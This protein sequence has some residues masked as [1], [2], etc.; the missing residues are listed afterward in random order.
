MRSRSAVL[1]QLVLLVGAGLLPALGQPTAEEIEKISGAAPEKA[2]ARPLRPRKLLVFSRNEGFQHTSI[3][4][5]A[6]AIEILGQ[7]TSAFEVVQSEDLGLFTPE[8]LKEFDAVL[9]NN[10][11]GFKLGDTA[12]DALLDF[13]K[14]GKGLVGIHAASANFE[15]WPEGT[16][17]FGAKFKSHPWVAADEWAVRNDDPDHPLNAAFGGQGFRVKEEIYAFTDFYRERE[18]VLLSL[19]LSDP[20]TGAVP[21]TETFVPISWVHTIGD[22]RVFFCSLGHV[23]DLFWTPAVLQHYLDGI[24]FALGD[25]KAD[26][27]PSEADRNWAF[28]ALIADRSGA[29][30]PLLNAIAEQMR[31]AGQDA[32][33]LAELERQMLRV[34]RSEATPD[35]KRAICEPL[36]QIATGASVPVAAAL[37]SDPELSHMARAVLEGAG[38]PEAAAA[39]RSAL[40]ELSG[41]LKAGAITSLANLRD[42]EAAASLAALISDPD[43]AV[44]E[45]AIA[46]LGRIG[47]PEAAE[48]LRGARA[49][50]ELRSA[51]DD[52]RAVCADGLA[53]EGK[54]AE[55]QEIYLALA[56][57]SRPSR[58]RALGLRGLVAIGSPRALGLVLAWLRGT[59]TE[60]QRAA[61]RASASLQDET[62]TRELL[63]AYPEL[64]GDLQ[65]ALLDALS[66]RG[67]P[68]VMPVAVN[69][70]A[71][72][73]AKMRAVGLRAVGRLGGPG[74]VEPLAEVASRGDRAEKQAARQCLARLQGA[75]VDQT[76]LRLARE[77]TAEVRAVLMGTLADRRMRSATP[78]LLAAARGGDGNV[79]AEALKALGRLAGEGQIGELVGI[80]TAADSGGVRE[81]AQGAL[82]AVA[83]R[84]G[85]ADQTLQP[86]FAALPEASAGNRCVL[87]GVLGDVGGDRALAELTKAAESTEAD[88]KRAAVVALAERWEDTRPLATLLAVAKSDAGDALRVQALRGHLRL[89]GLDASSR[90]EDVVAKIAEAVAIARRP[91]EKKQALSLLRERR[92]VSAVELAARCLDDPALVAEAGDTVLHLVAPQIRGG[93]RQPAVKGPIA[94]AALEKVIEVAADDKLRE[95]AELR[96]SAI[97]PAPWEGLDVGAVTIPGIS[98]YSDGVYTFRAS[99][100]DI[101]GQADAFH[102][103]SQPL[104][105]DVSI[106]AHVVS[107]ENTHV[108]AKAGVMIRETLDAESVNVL[109]CVSPVGNVAFQWRKRPGAAAE[110]IGPGISAAPPYW[111]KLTRAGDLLTGYI[112][113]DGQEWQ[114]VGEQTVEMAA[115]V[116]VGPAVTSHNDAAATQAV[117]ES[118]E[119]MVN[120]E[121]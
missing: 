116:L 110:V 102:F 114:K 37:L 77:G 12:R 38:T 16:E 40:P 50:E 95:R 2:T 22:G 1:L 117:I 28:D 39:L 53:A 32:G 88:V 5:G 91:E 36:S 66:E 118:V 59:D 26:T 108:W 83:R 68:A 8:G 79:A 111:V 65:A 119:V 76:V 45:A 35:T 82:V 9:F 21:H 15:G 107:L 97:L 67:D 43:A 51:L 89:L 63:A 113:P 112:S 90:P 94:M 27:A 44:A 69:A 86:L 46:G 18:R 17:L 115:D 42:R 121:R 48:A 24:Q 13:V 71:S 80:L 73:D 87:L 99:G 93:V 3:P 25:L 4:Y 109:M 98:S 34:L 61:A 78:A 74:A 92:V 105:G 56:D 20:R 120:D 64:A 55:A 84:V 14:G 60:L 103:V 11:Y 104:S 10:G 54:T 52:A 23:H 58:T 100:W 6:K 47:G 41:K 72:E 31:A 57:E 29:I 19:D 101:W 106:S 33:Q 49:P 62:A 96:R 30:L 75:E 7:K 85:E 81:A 70:L